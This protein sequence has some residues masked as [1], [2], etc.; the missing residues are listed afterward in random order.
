MK[1][2]YSIKQLE[3]MANVLRQDVIKML[4]EA[5]SGH[6]AGALGLA[7]IFAALYFNVLQHNPKKPNWPNRDRLCLSCGHVVPVR[8]AAMARVG[9]FPLKELKTLRK[10]NSR[11]QGHP[12]FIDLPG[13]EHSSGPLGQGTS[14]A[15][16]KALALKL[17]KNKRFVFCVTSDGEHQEGQTW[18]AV[19]SAGKNKLGNLIFILDRNYIQI[20]GYTEQV[21]PIDSVKEKYEA[22]NWYVIE[23]DGHKIE[24]IIEAFE[25]AKEIKSKPVLILANTTSG[26]GVS[27]MEGKYEWHGKAPNKVQANKAL[28]DLSK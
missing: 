23:I 5:G 18:E 2:K 12:S 8:Y 4:V 13:L 27:F 21:M 1:K 14:V 10:L 7:D 16:G 15:V 22:F 17:K 6:P 11:L 19:M 20:D 3:K 25:K 24:E 26:K 9:Y 28:K